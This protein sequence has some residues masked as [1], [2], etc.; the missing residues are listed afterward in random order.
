MNTLF[1]REVM[2]SRIGVQGEGEGGRE[3][4]REGGEKKCEGMREGKR[5][6]GDQSARV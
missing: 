3:E 6:G 4:E 5:E 1:S 2:R